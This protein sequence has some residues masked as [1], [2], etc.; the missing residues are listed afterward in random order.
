MSPFIVCLPAAFPQL[1]HKS[2]GLRMAS[3]TLKKS[4]SVTWGGNWSGMLGSVVYSMLALTPNFAPLSPPLFVPVPL[5]VS[6]TLCVFLSHWCPYFE[7][8]V[9]VPG[10]SPHPEA[11]IKCSGWPDLSKHFR[12]FSL[13]L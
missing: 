8:C 1:E 10:M 7:V 3:Q 9:K 13:A 12:A 5:S 2:T 4:C 6:V 11:Y